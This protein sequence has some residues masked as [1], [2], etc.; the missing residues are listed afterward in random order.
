MATTSPTQLQA[1][2]VEPQS[3]ITPK[4][5]HILGH[6]ISFSISPII[7]TAAFR[8]HGLPHTY[9]IRE[10]SNVDDF[11]QLVHDEGFGGASVT[12]PHKLAVARFCDE[13]SVHA[14]AIGAVNTL[15]VR[16]SWEGGRRRRVI[17]GE[18]TD[19]SGLYALIV[20]YA[21]SEGGR[22][23]GVGLVIGAGGAARA[24][25]YAMHQAGFRRIMVVNRTVPN[26]E[27]IAEDFRELFRVEVVADLERP[28]EAPEVVIGT[29]PADKTAEE[30][31]AGLFRRE[32]GLCIDM[33]YKP[34]DTPLLKVA[35]RHG[36]WTTVP[37]VEVLLYQAFD[38]FRLWTGREAPRDVMEQA[39]E[40]HERRL[41]AL[42]QD[43]RL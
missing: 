1:T 13:L 34:R 4:H 17:V 2:I 3:T 35:R 37:G 10:S 33:S 40:E 14:R 23:P 19:W 7:H 11:A 16:N 24:A 6:S 5:F 22:V 21:S 31:F 29:I 12:M 41:E 8:H 15:V 43:A 18:N 42:K 27:R 39:V 20:R 38:Q 26:A 9:D 36:E 25:L 32:R 28:P 30:S